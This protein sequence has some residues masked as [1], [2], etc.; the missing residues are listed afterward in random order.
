MRPTLAS[1]ATASYDRASPAILGS[2]TQTTPQDSLPAATAKALAMAEVPGQSHATAPGG[3]GRRAG[4]V[5]RHSTGRGRQ[6]WPVARHSAHRPR[7]THS[8]PPQRRPRPMPHRAS[9]PLQHRPRLT[10]RA[11]RPPQ[12]R[13]LPTCRASR[14]CLES[15]P[16]LL[17]CH[18]R[19]HT[20]AGTAAPRRLQ[21]GAR[22]AGQGLQ[23]H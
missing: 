15:L 16:I 22:T 1:R 13:P 21:A 20:W 7:P 6:A 9:R 12:H 8:R 23:Y 4:P 11:S 19:A 3:S 10:L 2:R 14:P 18:I 5:S 17:S